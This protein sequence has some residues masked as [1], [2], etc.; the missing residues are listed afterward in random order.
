MKEFNF[1]ALGAIEDISDDELMVITGAVAAIE[2]AKSGG[3][4]CTVS[5]ECH[6]N[7]VSPSSWLTCC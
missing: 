6:Y 3:V 1:E 7:S 5:H 2:A 4:F